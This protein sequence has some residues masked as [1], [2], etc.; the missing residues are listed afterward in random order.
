MAEW[1]KYAIAI[2]IGASLY[3][4]G[5]E[6]TK[7][8]IDTI[9]EKRVT[10]KKKEKIDLS[11]RWYTAWQTSREEKEKFNTQLLEIKQRGDKITMENIEK[12][13]EDKLGG[14]LWRGECK[15]YDNQHLLG[16][17]LPREPNVIS[18]GTIYFLLNRRCNFMVG[19]WVGCNYDYGF[20]WGYGVIAKEK[21]FAHEKM[22][23]LL[24]SQKND[25]SNNKGI[26]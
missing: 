18:K 11:G 10:V 17:Y 16:H 25:L 4:I 24:K 2:L 26:N 9:R 5:Y 15:L 1:L 19:K 20:T 22:Q 3:A 8:V 21:D 13:P 6:I 12:S 23:E 14:Y 7:S